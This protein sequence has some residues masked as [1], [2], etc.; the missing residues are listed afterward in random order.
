[1]LIWKFHDASQI[2]ISKKLNKLNGRDK[3]STSSLH[4]GE[5][6]FRMTDHKELLEHNSWTW[7]NA[8]LSFRKI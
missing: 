4:V 2:Y 8:W 1:M 6:S 3:I 7:E 5:R